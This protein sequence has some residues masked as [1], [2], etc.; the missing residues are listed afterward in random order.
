VDRFEMKSAGYVVRFG[1]WV[2]EFG[3]KFEVKFEVVESSL[4]NK[5]KILSKNIG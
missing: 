4:G 2:D 1:C 5:E 3:V